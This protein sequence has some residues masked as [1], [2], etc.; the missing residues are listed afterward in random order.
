[1]TYVSR[2]TKYDDEEDSFVDYAKKITF[3]IFEVEGRRIE[4]V[5][6]E[7]AD[8]TEEEIEEQIREDE[9]E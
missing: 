8:A 9:E 1:M 2:F 4:K 6:V 7:I 3:T 5:K